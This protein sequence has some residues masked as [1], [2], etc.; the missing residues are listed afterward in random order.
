MK[1]VPGERHFTL[2]AEKEGTGTFFTCSTRNRSVSIEDIADDIIFC[3]SID[4][5]VGSY[6]NQEDEL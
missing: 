1:G 4:I 6:S 3:V 5:Q 2:T